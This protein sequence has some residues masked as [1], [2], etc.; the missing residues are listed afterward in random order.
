MVISLIEKIM[1]NMSILKRRY[2]YIFVLLLIS[3]GQNVHKGKSHFDYIEITYSNGWTGGKTIHIDSLGVA[4]MCNYQISSQHEKTSCFVDTLGLSDVEELN[5]LV[6]GIVKQ[7]IDTLYNGHCNDCES[8]LIEIK[9]QGNIVRSQLIG[10]N[11]F[12]NDI[13]VL[14]KRIKDLKVSNQLTDTTFTFETAK[15]IKLKRGI[16][17]NISFNPPSDR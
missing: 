5:L 15:Y 9:Q 17:N 10:L 2:Y 1:L 3:C 12:T 4:T 7:R 14:A 16:D 13:A 6:G 8:C 11:R